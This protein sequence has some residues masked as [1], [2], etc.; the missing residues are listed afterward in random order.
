MTKVAL[1]IALVMLLGGCSHK[2]SNTV[3]T[4][5]DKWV[6][7]DLDGEKVVCARLSN[8]ELTEDAKSILMLWCVDACE[9]RG[10][11]TIEMPFEVRIIDDFVFGTREHRAAMRY[12]P[13]RCLPYDRPPITETKDTIL[14]PGRDGKVPECLGALFKDNKCPD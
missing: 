10:L 4:P 6:F 13:Q 11:K 8:P 1:C 7:Q 5:G 2:S 14:P 9:K 3:S 12:L